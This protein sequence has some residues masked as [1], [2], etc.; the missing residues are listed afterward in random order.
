MV[1]LSAVAA[2]RFYALRVAVEH[3]LENDAVAR[4]E[5]LNLTARLGNP[6]DD[7]VPQINPRI[8]RKSRRGDFDIYIE[9][10]NV[11]ICSAYAR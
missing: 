7:L 3:G 8:S 10:H 6:S 2:G 9:E 4:R 11:E 5:T 1:S